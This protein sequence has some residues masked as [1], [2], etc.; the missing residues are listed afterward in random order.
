[1]SITGKFVF[2]RLTLLIIY[3]HGAS[4]VVRLLAAGQ[5]NLGGTFA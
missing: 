5:Y 2:S 4:R 1:M 3:R